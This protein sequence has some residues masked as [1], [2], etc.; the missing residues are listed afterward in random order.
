MLGDLLGLTL[1]DIDGLIPW[2]GEELG[3]ILGE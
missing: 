1:G 3:D 2:L